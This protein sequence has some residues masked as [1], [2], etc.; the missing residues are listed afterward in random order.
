MKIY[1]KSGH[2]ST[3]C[4]LLIPKDWEMMRIYGSRIPRNTPTML[5]LLTGRLDVNSQLIDSIPEYVGPGARTVRLPFFQRAFARR[6]HPIRSIP[7]LLSAIFRYREA[8]FIGTWRKWENR[9]NCGHGFG[10]V[11][12][13]TMSMSLAYNVTMAFSR[14]PWILSAKTT[15]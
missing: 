15:A 8:N 1:D 7:R 4:W 6:P 12:H 2:V 5:S 9:R 13:L 14:F 10:V 11:G 3:F